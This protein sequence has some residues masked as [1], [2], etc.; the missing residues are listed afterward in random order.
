MRWIMNKIL[1][2][3]DEE[4]IRKFV[5]ISLKRENFEV[6]EAGTGEDGIELVSKES[7]DVVILDI[8]LPGIDGRCV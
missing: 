8:M 3:E 7:P 1:L 2:I 4:H 6:I 5:K